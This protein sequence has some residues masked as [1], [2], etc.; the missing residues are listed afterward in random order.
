MDPKEELQSKKD[1]N[2][3]KVD[4]RP[5]ERQMQ[6]LY[7]SWS[8]FLFVQPFVWIASMTLHCYYCFD[9]GLSCTTPR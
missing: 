1:Q 6:S 9:L 4:T 5:V 8:P 2:T 7:A 3:H